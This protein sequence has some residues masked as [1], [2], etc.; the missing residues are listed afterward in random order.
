[1]L[2]R[3]SVLPQVIERCEADFTAEPGRTDQDLVLSRAVKDSGLFVYLHV[4]A[5]VEHPIDLP[6]TMEHKHTR[7]AGTTSGRFRR[8]WR[9]E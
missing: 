5:L 6:S 3:R 7:A 8:D 4:P 2:L 1:V 9:R